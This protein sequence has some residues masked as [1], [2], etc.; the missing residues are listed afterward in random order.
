MSCRGA[1]YTA[2]STTMLHRLRRGRNSISESAITDNL[3][4]AGRCPQLGSCTH[5]IFVL[6]IGSEAPNVCSP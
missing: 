1:E 2:S 4:G 6:V 5:Q 3:V